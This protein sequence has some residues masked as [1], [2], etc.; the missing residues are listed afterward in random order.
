MGI[1]GGWLEGREREW[2]EGG[3]SGKK[4]DIFLAWE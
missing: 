1:F 4:V 3:F 2:V